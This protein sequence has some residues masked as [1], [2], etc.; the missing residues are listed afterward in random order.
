MHCPEKTLLIDDV[1]KSKISKIVCKSCGYITLL[2]KAVFSL[3]TGK[4][5]CD[6]CGNAVTTDLV[7]KFWIKK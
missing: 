6:F 3:E 7:V 2:D 1:E 5:V 4:F